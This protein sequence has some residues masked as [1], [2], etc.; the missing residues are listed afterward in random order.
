MFKYLLLNGINETTNFEE[1]LLDFEIAFP[2]VY[3]QKVWLYQVGTFPNETFLDVLDYF[4]DAVDADV[5][6]VQANDTLA[7]VKGEPIATQINYT[8][9]VEFR[10]G[11]TYSVYVMGVGS[12]LQRRA[13]TL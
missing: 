12:L 10:M 3:P 11:L 8:C 5:G 1:S 2:L 7:I 6:I 9:T 13:S 4:L